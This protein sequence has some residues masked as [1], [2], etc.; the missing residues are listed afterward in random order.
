MQLSMARPVPGC[1]FQFSSG[2]LRCCC[3]CD[4]SLSRFVPVRRQVATPS[5]LK[6]SRGAIILASTPLPQS[7]RPLWPIRIPRPLVYSTNLADVDPVQLS[8]LWEKTLMVTREP[9]K[10]MKALRHSFMFVIV[11]AEQEKDDLGLRSTP[12]VVGIGRA[13]SDGSFIAT[14]CDV[15]VDP[16]YQKQGIGRRIVKRLV[17]EIKKKGG[18]SGFAVFP[19]PI[20]RQ[21]FWL[22][23]FRSDR[24]Y[25]LMGYRGK[26]EKSADITDADN[27]AQVLGTEE[28]GE[29]EEAKEP[30]VS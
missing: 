11:L 4:V 27:G 22:I 10:I 23:G 20:A 9:S 7:P 28:V 1:S 2:R 6:S 30:E 29:T 16:E 13:V 3:S 26:E 5:Q 14:I 25:R 12:K 24:K 17:Q 15:A 8:E 19:P 18:P 21:F